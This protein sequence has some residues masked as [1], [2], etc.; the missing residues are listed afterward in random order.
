MIFFALAAMLIFAALVASLTGLGPIARMINGASFERQYFSVMG[1][2]ADQITAYKNYLTDV[3]AS[4]VTK[5][6]LSSKELAKRVI[7]LS[8]FVVSLLCG[9][10]WFV[11]VIYNRVADLLAR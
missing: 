11:F 6:E 8:P 3:A 10:L 9:L 5:N 1:W 7:I 2:D 4:A